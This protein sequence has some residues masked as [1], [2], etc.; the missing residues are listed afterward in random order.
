MRLRQGTPAEKLRCLPQRRDLLV[1]VRLLRALGPRE[2][3]PLLRAEGAQETTKRSGVKLRRV[4]QFSARIS[5]SRPLPLTVAEQGRTQGSPLRILVTVGANP[6]IHLF[7]GQLVLVGA[8]LCIRPVFPGPCTSSH[9]ND[10]AAFLIYF[11]TLVH[12][13]AFDTG[14][15]LDQPRRLPRTQKYAILRLR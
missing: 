3:L 14:G 1:L 6:C 13:P 9:L 2:A 12:R 5:P 10:L 11:R 15:R 8:N 7:S 4:R